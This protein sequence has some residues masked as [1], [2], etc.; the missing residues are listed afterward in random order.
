MVASGYELPGLVV[1]VGENRL[2]GE[3]RLD[4][5]GPRPRLGVIVTAPSIQLD[6][7]PLPERLTE[8][9]RPTVTAQGVRATARGLAR[10]TERLMSAGFLRR[11]D[12]VLDVE[13][14]EVVSGRDRLADG[15]L[16]IQ[17]IEGRLYLGPAQ[18]NLPGGTL[19]LAIA[20]DPTTPEVDFKAGA[21]IERFDYG[22]LARH[23][24]QAE[25]VRGLFS[26]NLELAGKAPSLDA[27][28]RHANG[29]MDFAIWP[30][31]VRGGIFNMWSVNLLLAVLPLIDPGGNSHVN[32]IVGRFDLKDGVLSDD[33]IMIDTTRVRV[34]GAGSANL[35]TDEL[36]FV[37]RPRAKGLAL[38][39]L[40]TPLRVT[41]TLTD[42]RIGVERRD[43]PES[44]LRLIASPILLPL[45]RL[46]LGPLPR[47]GA[48]L[49]TDPLRE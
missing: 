1:S 20:Y 46:T 17:V 19:E 34:S 43:L 27:I 25:G 22:V 32:C 35:A 14:G 18:V 2:T 47:D 13:V 38:F 37:F 31:D 42:Y 10:A 23:L 4:L 3:G 41:G 16:R 45:E 26:L 30:E 28:T 8:D 49:C 5:T 9:P 12:A 36:A 40:Q 48:D 21:Y 7:F 39:R 33:K 15:T 24:H 11:L 29:R 44:I 6:D